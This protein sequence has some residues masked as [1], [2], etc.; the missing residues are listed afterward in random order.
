MIYFKDFPKKWIV[1]DTYVHYVCVKNK[2]KIKVI[3]V[4]FKDR[5]YG[6]SKW[7]N[8]YKIFLAIFYLIYFTY[9]KLPFQG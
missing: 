8:N 2:V 5:I 6:Q 9:F 4:V 3:D 1:L 7:K